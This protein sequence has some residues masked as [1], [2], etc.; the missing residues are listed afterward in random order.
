MSVFLQ[1]AAET[2]TEIHRN[3]AV[4]V[5]AFF[6]VMVIIVQQG[7]Q[8]RRNHNNKQQRP[9]AIVSPA[10]GAAVSSP[11][12]SGG[13]GGAN[14]QRARELRRNARHGSGAL[15]GD[16][17]HVGRVSLRYVVGGPGRRKLTDDCWFAAHSLRVLGQS[18]LDARYLDTKL[19]GWS[20]AETNN[21]RSFAEY[22]GYRVA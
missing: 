19:Y 15:R 17:E 2:K 7:F 1:A 14:E 11:T 3:V 8:Q 12:R 10:A 9:A 20:G 18:I 5:V 13:G 22:L 4:V 6:V 21:R 16:A